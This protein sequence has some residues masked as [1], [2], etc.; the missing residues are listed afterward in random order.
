LREPLDNGKGQGAWLLCA[1][2]VGDGVGRRDADR[3][4]RREALHPVVGRLGLDAEDAYLWAQCHRRGCAAAQQATA[5]DGSQQGVERS[6][7]LDQLERGR[8]LAG[9]DQRVV[10]WGHQR[11]PAFFGQAASDRLAIFGQAVVAHDR[12]AV[13][14]GRLDFQLRR[15]GRHDHGGRDAQLAGGQANPLRVVARRKRHDASLSLL[16]GQAYQAVV[17]ATKFEGAAPL[18]VLALQEDSP[19]YQ[20]VE[21]AGRCHG[22]A[23]GDAADAGRR[24]ADVFEADCEGCVGRHG[25]TNL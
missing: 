12:G 11:Q 8:A 13:A 25:F 15:V 5:T 17:G 24:L 23:V 18:Q 19:A 9:H 21:R 1:D 2:A 14:G 3:M 6:R 20:V 4:A 16:L 7:I 10:V 22:G